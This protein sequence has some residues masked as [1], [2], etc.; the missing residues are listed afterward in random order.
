MGFLR[1]ARAELTLAKKRL[2][3]TALNMSATVSHYRVRHRV[4]YAGP[5]A[6]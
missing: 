3:C 2:C 1:R 4:N 5:G 6:G